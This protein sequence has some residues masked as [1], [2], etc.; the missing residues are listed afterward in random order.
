MNI[1]EL[2]R[3]AGAAVQHYT[4]PPDTRAVLQRALEALR[5]PCDRWNKKQ[6]LIVNAAIAEIE[7]ILK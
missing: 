4:T 2:K 5:L 1:E 6:T 3:L 7:G